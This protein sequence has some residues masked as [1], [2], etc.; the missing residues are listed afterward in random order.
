MEIIFEIM[1]IIALSVYIWAGGSAH[2]AL[3][4]IGEYF[5]ERKKRLSTK[6]VCDVCF[7]RIE[8]VK[9]DVE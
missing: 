5:E 8:Q 2:T 1:K 4:R 7:D 9:E 3:C 6:K